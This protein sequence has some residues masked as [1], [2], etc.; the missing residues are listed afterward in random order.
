MVSLVSKRQ[1][2]RQWVSDHSIMG[3]AVNRRLSLAWVIALVDLYKLI[4]KRIA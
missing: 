2:L 3:A 1:K 4:R